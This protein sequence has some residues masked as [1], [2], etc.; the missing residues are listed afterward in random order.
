MRQMETNKILDAKIVIDY[1]MEF[2]QSTE[3][4]PILMVMLSFLLFLPSA[5]FDWLLLRKKG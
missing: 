2:V 3:I 1:K 4:V 5:C